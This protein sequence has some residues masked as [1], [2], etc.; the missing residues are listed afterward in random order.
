MTRLDIPNPFGAPVFH[1][2]SVGSTMDVS[3][4]LARDA[5]SPPGRS[6]HGTVVC[7]DFQ[8]SG[9]GRV[10][11]R[12]WNVGRRD[13]LMFTVLLRFPGVGGIPRAL[14]LRTGL[15]VALAIE[16]FAL[17]LDAMV[18]W[19]NDVMLPVRGA[20]TFRKAV[21]ILAEAEGGDVHIGVGVNVAQREFPEGLRDRA[22][23]IALASGAE[24]DGG[25]RFAL[26][27]KILARLHAELETAG[28]RWRDLIEARLYM[29]GAT[30]GF[31]E[32]PADSA[33]VFSGAIAG[34]G[35]DGEL[36]IVREGETVPRAFVSGELSIRHDLAYRPPT[37]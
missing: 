33:R 17:G 36:L 32:G 26:L 3:K 20:G 27:E 34:I 6:P 2:E 22:T 7:A 5:E 16:D 24:I 8:E 15:A 23:S 29:M 28:D 30:A 18:K 31:A 37:R 1:E 9:R 11:G 10:R 19:P 21:G 13:G 14:T 4:A 35:R 12:A 25:R